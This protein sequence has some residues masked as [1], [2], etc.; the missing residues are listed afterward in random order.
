[1]DTLLHFFLKL[2]PKPLAC[3]LEMFL[4]RQIT[5]IKDLSADFKG[6]LESVSGSIMSDSL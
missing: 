5:D 4:Q 2:P 6:Y 1:M 3:Q